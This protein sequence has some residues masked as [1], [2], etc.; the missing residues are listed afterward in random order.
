VTA[1]QPLNPDMLEMKWRLQQQ[2]LQQTSA[3]LP[4]HLVFRRS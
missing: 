4:L 1:Q 3:P 2:Q